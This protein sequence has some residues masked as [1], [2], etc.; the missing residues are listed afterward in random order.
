MMTKLFGILLVWSSYVSAASVFIELY[1]T[2]REGE[3]LNL[4]PSESRREA[5]M[6]D[7]GGK[8]FLSLKTPLAFELAPGDVRSLDGIWVSNPSA[9]TLVKTLAPLTT[10]RVLMQT[11]EIRVADEAARNAAR[12]SLVEVTQ[13][14]VRPRTFR[15]PNGQVISE[16]MVEYFINTI[17]KPVEL[18]LPWKV[19]SILLDSLDLAAVSGGSVEFDGMPRI[20][21]NLVVTPEGGTVYRGEARSLSRGAKDVAKVLK[22]TQRDLTDPLVQGRIAEYRSLQLRSEKRRDATVAQMMRD[23]GIDGSSRWDAKECKRALNDL[24]ARSPNPRPQATAQVSGEAT[25]EMPD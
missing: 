22:F 9:V 24:G 23:E 12:A 8:L 18:E 4:P 2:K 13:P 3:L 15:M 16:G 7:R 14:G 25:G 5:E 10:H 19:S 21:T 1:G 6:E 11:T 20:M 17:S